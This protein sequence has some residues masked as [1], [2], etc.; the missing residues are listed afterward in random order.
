MGPDEKTKYTLE[1]TVGSKIITLYS[2]YERIVSEFCKR[3][4][5]IVCI[6]DEMQQK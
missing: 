1:I 5:Q 6:K 3:L 4:K 2:D